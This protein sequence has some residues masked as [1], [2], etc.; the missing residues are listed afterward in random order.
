MDESGYPPEQ[1]PPYGYPAQRQPRGDPPQQPSGYPPPDYQQ[2]PPPG[3]QQDPWQQPPPDPW[4]Q[5]PPYGPAPPGRISVRTKILVAIGVLVVGIGGGVW[6]AGDTSHPTD[7]ATTRA[8]SEV[9][10]EPTSSAGTNPFM[11]PVGQDQAGVTPPAGTTGTFSGDTAGLF[12]ESGDRPSCDAQ[13]LG[14]NLAADPA[15]SAAWAEALGIT[16]ADIPGYVASLNPVVLR[17]DTAVTSYGYADNTFTA[18]PA[19]LQAGTAVFVNGLGEPRVKCFSGNPLTAAQPY[20]QP[21]YAGPAWPHFAPTTV[22]YVRAAPTVINNYTVVDIH[23][24]Q[25]RHRPSKRHWQG[26]DGGFCTHHRDSPK[27]PSTLGT[28][29][30]PVSD[31]APADAVAARKAADQ[32][33]A[34]ADAKAAEVTALEKEVTLARARAQ[35]NPTPENL[36]AINTAQQRVDEARAANAKLAAEKTQADQAAGAANKKAEEKEGA[37]DPAKDV[38]TPAPD[39]TPPEQPATG[40]TPD[41]RSLLAP[42]KPGGTAPAAGTGAAGGSGDVGTGTSGTGPGPSHPF[43]VDG[44]TPARCGGVAAPPPGCAPRGTPPAAGTPTS[45][46]QPTGV[47]RHGT[48]GH[49]SAPAPE[50]STPEASTPEQASQA[51]ADTGDQGGG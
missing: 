36:A 5:P 48:P 21:S 46:T 19:V 2:Q 13:T 26:E 27:C 22:I 25:P 15:K 34:A 14:G 45:T 8:A 29:A 40:G 16:G 20:R 7:R 12:A 51:P 43:A 3:Y 49:R 23:D 38:L 31:K 24:N 17:A 42:V 33:T 9:E 35:E 44:G 28:R 50:G 47:P 39:G 30:D 1:T 18:Y 4:R 32:A 6:W 37:T 11:P 10:L 41:Q